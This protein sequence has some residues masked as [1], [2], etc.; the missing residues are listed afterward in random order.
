LVLQV[1]PEIVQSLPGEY[2]LEARGGKGGKRQKQEY[3]QE[4]VNDEGLERD[5]AASIAQE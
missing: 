5:R 1:L 4:R 3:Y 2:E